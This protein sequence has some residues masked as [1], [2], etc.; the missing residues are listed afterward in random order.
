MRPVNPRRRAAVIAVSGT[1]LGAVGLGLLAVPAG[2]G[3]APEL[4]D[5]EPQNLV[6]S[7]LRAEPPALSGTITVDNE[8]GIPQLGRSSALAADSGRVYYDGEGR[9]RLALELRGGEH[10]V[11]ADGTQ[12]WSYDSGRNSASR[13]HLPDAAAASPEM[14]GTPT[15]P[16][17]AAQ[18][19]LEFARETSTVT[20][21]G[22][23]TVADRA[24]Y[25]L[26]LTPKPTEK[27]LLRETRIAVDAETRMPLRVSVFT[28]GDTEPVFSLGFSEIDFGEQPADLF[29]FTPPESAEVTEISPRHDDRAQA[30]VDDLRV[31]GDGWDS[32]VV[33][34]MSDAV[35]K[36]NG[37]EAGE[38][39]SNIGTRVNGDYGSGYLVKTRA[40]TALLTDDG[41]IAVGAVPEQVLAD[42]LTR[43]GR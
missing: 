30:P 5:V 21:D 1:T 29:T 9:A 3:E 40:A 37:E 35:G 12:V 31:V 23:A 22:T 15:D 7:V 24:A 18:K 16:A 27:T 4:P 42:A 19:S 32:V 13:L 25:E 38:L 26:V 39:L 2:A 8:L 36:S 33:A 34:R 10:T 43:D 28:H 14:H 6:E 17:T 41:R 11:V 20:V